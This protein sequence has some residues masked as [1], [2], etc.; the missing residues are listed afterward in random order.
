MLTCDTP[1]CKL[2]GELV[3][4]KR[5]TCPKCKNKLAG[6]GTGFGKA[7]KDNGGFGRGSQKETPSSFTRKPSRRTKSTWRGKA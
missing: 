3:M 6:G 4:E 1:G 7:G 5:T 2:R